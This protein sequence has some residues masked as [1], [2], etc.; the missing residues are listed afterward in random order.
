MDRELNQYKKPAFC[1][2]VITERCMLKCK[3]CNMWKSK[4]DSD[5]LP[6]E[7]WKRFIDSFADFVESK[8]QVQFVGGEPLFKKGILD[9]V[10]YTANKG[11]S[12]TMTT[13]AHLID[14]KMARNLAGSG[15][16]TLVIS[17]DSIKKETHDFLRGV[18][19]TYDRLMKAIDFLS[20][21]N[22]DSLKLH[23]VSTIMQPNLDDMLEL[24]EWANKNRAIE[25]ISF[26]A[27]M[28]P[29][30]TT[31]DNMWYKREEF[32]FLWPADMRKVEYILDQLIDLKK[33]GYKITN[34]ISQ[35]NIFKSYFKNPD[36]F[37]RISRCN[38]GYNSLTV[39]TYGKIFLCNS[40][41]PVGDIQEKKDI[42]EFWFSEKTNQVRD[43]IRKCRDNCKLIVN[44]FFEEDFTSEEKNNH[45]IL[46]K[47]ATE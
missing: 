9:L 32:S 1:D 27:V 18:E 30:Y 47:K 40:M 11:F 7:I 42:S 26:Q 34:P 35:F 45:S 39:N 21:F 20:K 28:Q 44:C 38:L 41:E 24:V 14:E 13:N 17:L 22:G 19:G 43:K 36:K 4:T 37:I 6:V 8:A 10:S 33:K 46:L 15:L 29:F 3:M 5:E 2:L 25:H 23:V 31:L 12:T 16:T